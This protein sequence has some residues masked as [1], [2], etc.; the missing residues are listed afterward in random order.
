MRCRSPSPAGVSKHSPTETL[1]STPRSVALTGSVLLAAVILSVASF[2]EAKASEAEGAPLT[3]VNAQFVSV[4]DPSLRTLLRDLGDTIA[5]RHGERDVLITTANHTVVTF[6]VGDRRYEIGPFGAQARYAP[7]TKNGI[8]YLPLKELL[9]TLWVAPVQSGRD[10]VLEPQLASIDVRSTTTGTTLVARAAVPLRPRIVQRSSTRVVYQF[11]GIGSAVGGT[12]TLNGGG[13]RD[14]VIRTTGTLATAQTFL[15]VD[16]LAG[17]TLSQPGS[18]DGRDF[19]LFVRAK[20]VAAVSATPQSGATQVPREAQ[21]T[22]VDV[23]P[24][25][26][27]F[28]V[29]IV[30]SGDA[31]YTWHRLAAPDNRFWIDVDGAHLAVPSRDDRWNGHVT[32]VRV[33]QDTPSNVRVA[34]SLAQPLLI[35]VVPSGSGLRIIVANDVALNPSR[36]GYGSIGSIVSSAQESPPPTPAPEPTELLTPVPLGA[37]QFAPREYIPTNPRLIVIDPGHGGN[38]PGTI[39]RGVEEKT[40]TLDMALRLRSILLAHGW[41]VRM[42]RTT[43]TA[44]DPDAQTDHDEL[45]ARDDVANENGARLFI[46]IHV[47]AYGGS[48]IPKGTTSYYSKSDDVPL[49]RDVEDAIAREAG[50]QDDGI[51]KSR[52]YVTLHAL[53]PAVL[54]ETAF[55]TNQSDFAKLESP[56]W[57]QRIA[58]AMADGIE[59]YAR[60]FPAPTPSPGG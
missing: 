40:L 32:G 23:I 31:A 11:S 9:A 8:P 34:L 17:A 4:N 58:Q 21:V 37:Q 19:A 30:V 12:R 43:D 16:L 39:Y 2:R 54:V 55:L 52:L 28:T 50:T 59:T 53:M 10:L 22:G 42:T 41:Q 49:A 20:S 48:S 26:E 25:Q 60:D 24:T 5:W 35:T 7:Y 44:V 57:R 1:S 29:A 15:T 27:S 3:I 38:D 51:V 18:D 14:F 45:Q 46:A 36:S 6:T 33:D 56:A 13:I 47:N